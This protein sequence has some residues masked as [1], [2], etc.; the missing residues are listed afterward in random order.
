MYVKRLLTQGEAGNT[1]IRKVAER[2]QV[3]K[4]TVQALLK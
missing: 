2:F 4:S 1:S 3:S